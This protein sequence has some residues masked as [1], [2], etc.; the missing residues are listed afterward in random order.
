M[1][2]ISIFILFVSSILFAD[3]SYSYISVKKIDDEKKYKLGKELFFDQNLSSDGTVSCATCHMFSNGG[4]DNNRVS[5]GVNAQKGVVN[6]P[7]IFNTK[8]NIAQDWIGESKTIKGRSEIA[9][10]NKKEM[11][12][13]FDKAIDYIKSNQSLAGQFKEIYT[14]LTKDEIFE[15]IAYY[16]SYLT[17]PNS[18]FDKFINGDNSVFSEDEKTGYKLFK[19]YGCTSCHNGINIGG[20]MY[21]KFGLFRLDS[22]ERDDNLGRYKITK[23]EYDRYVFKVPSLRNVSRTSPYL[24]NGKVKSLKNVIKAMAKYQLDVDIPEDEISKIE[25]FLKTLNGDI[26]IER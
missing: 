11:A 20:N 1:V 16:V 17:T 26:P 2:K 25:L 4:A 6:T 23:K 14:N 8:F 13:S 7:S 24:H 10:L 5:F 9:F 19:N 18:K 12:G 21:Q 3:L 22:I 15:S